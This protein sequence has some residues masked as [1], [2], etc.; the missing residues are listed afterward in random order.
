MSYLVFLIALAALVGWGMYSST[1]NKVRVLEEE[2]GYLST[3]LEQAE[4]K[5]YKRPAWMPNN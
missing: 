3:M 5:P 4:G 1:L 2:I